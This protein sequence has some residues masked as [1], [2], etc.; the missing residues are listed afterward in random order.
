MYAETPDIF[1]DETHQ[2]AT[3]T[4][5]HRM[6]L[7]GATPPA[8]E[9]DP[10]PLP[11]TDTSKSVLAE[12]FIALEHSLTDTCLDSETADLLWS[13][14]NIFQR[15]CDRLS[16]G[17]DQL[18]YAIRT[19]IRIQ[20]G[21]E[22]QSAE[23]EKLQIRAKASSQALTYFEGQFSHAADLYQTHTGQPWIASRTSRQIRNSVTAAVI[24]SQSFLTAREKRKTEALAPEG[25]K[26]LISGGMDYADADAIF[27]AL[28][29]TRAKH[30]NM[31]LIHGG[32]P[33]G[34][35]LIAAKWASHRKV[36]QVTFKPD[37]NRYGKSRA[38]FVRN[39]AMLDLPP[40]GLLAF[41]GTGLT[42]NLI[43]KARNR[44]IPIKIHR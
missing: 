43:D 6:E 32:A 41:P 23:L 14:V 37:W 20:D 2:S 1:D 8:D 21:S 40:I 35:D 26:V 25:P 18:S 24:D 13:L 31:V 17:L 11:D 12:I 29:K 36:D 3:A 4:I 22:I 44:G 15:K 7:Y 39:D 33:R 28:D 19:S 5:M 34:T 30:P 38:G 16:N 42:A 10:R 9:V 27:A